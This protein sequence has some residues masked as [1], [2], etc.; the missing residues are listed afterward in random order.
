M[1]GASQVAGHLQKLIA[2]VRIGTEGLVV[3][4]RSMSDAK[5][6]KQVPFIHGWPPTNALRIDLQ[7]SP[8]S[9][10]FASANDLLLQAYRVRRPALRVMIFFQGRIAPPAAS[11]IWCRSTHGRIA[12]AGRVYPVPYS[13]GADKRGS[14]REAR[15]AGEVFLVHAWL[16]PAAPGLSIC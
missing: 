14:H 3:A 11:D 13:Q 9:G 1:F 8:V 5:L 6:V 7:F 16:C 4:D 2:H 15:Q 10:L 12:T